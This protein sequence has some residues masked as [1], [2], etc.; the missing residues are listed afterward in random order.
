[1]NAECKRCKQCACRMLYSADNDG[2][3]GCGYWG[4]MLSQDQRACDEFTTNSEK[5]HQDW[6]LGKPM[7][8]A[9]SRKI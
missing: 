6:P 1:M 5:V 3:F 4:F 9:A 8:T 2:E 7:K